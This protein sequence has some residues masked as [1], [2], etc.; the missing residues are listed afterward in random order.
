MK[1]TIYYI[2]LLRQKRYKKTIA[3]LSI[4][5]IYAISKSNIKNAMNFTY[6]KQLKSIILRFLF[7]KKCYKDF[8]RIIM[9]M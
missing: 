8:L 9:I 2:N 6:Q 1:F 3:Y 4:N 7:F 5:Y